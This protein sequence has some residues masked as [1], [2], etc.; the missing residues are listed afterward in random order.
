MKGASLVGGTEGVTIENAPDNVGRLDGRPE[1]LPAAVEPVMVGIDCVFVPVAPEPVITTF[2]AVSV[3]V[4]F[5]EPVFVAVDRLGRAESVA[6]ADCAAAP[7]VTRETARAVER[8]GVFD[9]SL[10]MNILPNCRVKS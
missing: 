2:E 1:S 5:A 6:A 8:R 3:P 9:R 10:M 4:V 7:I